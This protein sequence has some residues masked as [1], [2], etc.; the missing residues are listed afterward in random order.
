MVGRVRTILLILLL[1]FAIGSAALSSCTAGEMV[2]VMQMACCK[3][4][5]HECGMSDVP[6]QC[7]K[8]EKRPEHQFFAA[9]RQ[10]PDSAV[11]AMFVMV[12]QAPVADHLSTVEIAGRSRSAPLASPSPP[13]YILTSSFLI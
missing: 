3:G 11:Q 10:A 12:A 8:K 9:Q 7:C 4:G 2:P 5:H 6:S 13:L 1:I